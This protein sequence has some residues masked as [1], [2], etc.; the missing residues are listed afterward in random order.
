MGCKH[1]T[2]RKD[3]NAPVHPQHGGKNTKHKENEKDLFHLDG[4]VTEK[5]MYM[6]G[7]SA[8]SDSSDDEP[9]VEKR[10]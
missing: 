9:S 10:E 5:T 3:L 7:T 1:S 2:E 4:V 6:D 8:N